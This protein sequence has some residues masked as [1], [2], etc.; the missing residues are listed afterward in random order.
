MSP[1]DDLIGRFATFEVRRFGASGAFLA[2]STEHAGPEDP[3][4]LLIGSEIPKDAK[5]G[6]SLRAFV[7]LDSEGRPLATTRTPKLTLGDVGFLDVTASTAIGGFVDYG[8]PKELLVPFSEQTT[9][10]RVGARHPIGLYL[11]SSGRLA[12][13]MRVNKLLDQEDAPFEREQWVNGEAWR[14]D[15]NTGLFAIVERRFVGLVPASEP[16]SLSRGDAAK[17]R[18]TRV[19]PDGKIELSLRGHAHEELEKDARTILDAL[20]RLS[21]KKLK[22]TASPDEIRLLFGLSKKAF[23]RGVGRLLKQGLVAL[24]SDGSI[25]VKARPAGGS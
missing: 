18:V 23:K 15:P 12:G 4:L 11:D 16:H 9:E 25:E 20:A 7:Y 13:T 19:L 5:E 3:T 2:R 10:L 22:D 21:P 1:F 14:N 8:L 24:G 17:F 6:D